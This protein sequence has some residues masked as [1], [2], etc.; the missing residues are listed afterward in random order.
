MKKISSLY[1]EEIKNR[2]KLSTAKG[3]KEQK[4]YLAEGVRV[5]ATLIEAGH[6]PLQI[7]CTKPMLPQALTLSVEEYI[8]VVNEDVAQKLS[9]SK[10]PSGLVAVFK[11]P[12]QPALTQLSSGIVLYELADPGNVGTLIRTTAAMGQKTVVL[13]GGVDPWSPKVVQSTAGTIGFLNIFELSWEELVQNKQSL[14]LCGLVVTGG[15]RPDEINFSDTLLVVGNEAH[16][17]PV[18]TIQQCD[19][20]LTL[21]MPGKAESL[22]AA[23]AGSI[24]LYL[25]WHKK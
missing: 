10:T 23:V 24:A 25:A 5:C 11:I 15:N 7:Y 8:T 13:V 14:N 16:G 20:L 21:E 1:S 19:K 9:I 4:R 17:M 18:S 2:V 22:N 6:K 3:R 12:K